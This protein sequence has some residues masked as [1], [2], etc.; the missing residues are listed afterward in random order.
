[1][2]RS[3]FESV[4]VLRARPV[5]VAAMDE[6]RVVAFANCVR[7]RINNFFLLINCD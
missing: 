3:E 5:M 2:F 1:M 6:V 4:L 7:L